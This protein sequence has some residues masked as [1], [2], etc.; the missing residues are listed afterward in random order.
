M[1]T[2]STIGIV[3]KDGSKSRIY[4][5][6]IFNVVDLCL[7]YNQDLSKIAVVSIFLVCLPTPHILH[8]T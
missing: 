8:H 1:A 3:R 7:D 4:C 2:R 5:Q 6:I